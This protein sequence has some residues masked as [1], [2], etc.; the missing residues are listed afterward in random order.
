M[1]KINLMNNHDY[2]SLFKTIASQIKDL[3]E[4]STE[5]GMNAVVLKNTL[6]NL[7]SALEYLAADIKENFGYNGR[8]SF[9]HSS[10][11][12]ETFKKYV[13]QRFPELDK[14]Y[15]ELYEALK[16]EQPFLN[17]G[18]WLEVLV[19]KT[20]IVKHNQLEVSK[21][22]LIDGTS[23][24]GIADIDRFKKDIHIE[25]KDVNNGYHGDGSVTVKDGTI[26]VSNAK[27]IIITG[28]KRKAFIFESEDVEILP[29]LEESLAEVQNLVEEVY[30][31]FS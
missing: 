17:R 23:I 27:N 13:N 16:Q 18:N 5:E 1:S 9:P 14:N 2:K 30:Y 6:E 29:F 21:E 20:D 7:R 19:N 15:P 26:S 12:E 8:S 28:Q 4:T 25:L 24:L 31:Q 11:D 22:D 3:K 10:K